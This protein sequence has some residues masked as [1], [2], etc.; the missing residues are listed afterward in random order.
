MMWFEEGGGDLSVS[1]SCTIL[2]T[3]MR[4]PALGVVLE[5]KLL[6]GGTQL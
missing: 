2:Y 1:Q 5:G 6:C 4:E 3:L